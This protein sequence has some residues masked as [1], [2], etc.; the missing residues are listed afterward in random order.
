MAADRMLTLSVPMPA[1]SAPCGSASAPASSPAS[2]PH[3]S[4]SSASSAGAQ[5]TQPGPSATCNSATSRGKKPSSAGSSGAGSDTTPSASA[6]SGTTD[7]GRATGS[8]NSSGNSG[9]GG[10]GAGSATNGR[11]ASGRSGPS[12][13]SGPGSAQSAAQGPTPPVTSDFSAALAQS[14]AA[15]STDGAATPPASAGKPAADS[16]SSAP[17][18]GG[19]SSGARD[20][21]PATD[22]VSSTLT[23]LEQALAG[24]LAGAASA[25]APAGAPPPANSS[26]ATADG[27]IVA[28][29][30]SSAAVLDALLGQS[31]DSKAGS[32]NPAATGIPSGQ[33]AA[34]S[35]AATAV[36]GA[37]TGTAAALAAAVQLSSGSPVGSQQ[38]PDS[39][40]M[41]LASPVG[42]S[43]WTDELG[44]KVTW[45]AHQ[46]IESASLQLSPEHLG[47]L[48]VSISVHDGRASVWFGAAQPDTRAALQQ[49]LPH[50]R[51]LFAGQGLTLTDAGVSREP[52]RG[53][54]H[55]GSGRPAAPV[56]AATAVNVDSAG[57]RA[58]LAG[59]LGLLDT[60]A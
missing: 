11:G 49:S 32:S 55:Q 42:T 37:T 40:R 60:Y 15:T 21:H 59:G 18:D 30:K 19:R 25:P 39:S 38:P 43:A 54:G 28:G 7:K 36:T 27:A 52:P 57:T 16:D 9:S 51:Q 12:G 58:S 33:A 41:T 50:L 22:P 8:G 6:G 46:G 14:L 29:G 48:Q 56:S 35:P 23:L 24:A 1:P 2:S 44:A 53:Q 5:S 26:S 4:G 13:T 31:L 45:M 34:S 47:P 3:S 17:A 10:P 20:K